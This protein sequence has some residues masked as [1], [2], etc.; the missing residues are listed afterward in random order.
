MILFII[1]KVIVIYR[2]IISFLFIFLSLS[3]YATE[4]LIS[5]C[6]DRTTNLKEAEVSL[7]FLLL[8]KEKVFQRP[9][10]NCLDITTS[11][12][13]ANLLEKFL[14]KRYSL[15]NPEGKSNFKNL[16]EQQCQIE[17]R[18]TKSLQENGKDFRLGHLNIAKQDS[19][20]RQ[21]VSTSQLLLGFGYP[22]T[23]EIGER[24]FYIECR[25]NEAGVYQL[26]FSYNESSR[27]RVNSTISIKRGE[28]V[29]LAQI[30]NDLDTKSKILGFPQSLYQSAQGQEDISYELKIN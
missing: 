15:V 22:G 3:I 26:I 27:A 14:S 5:Y 30:I 11:G 2:L 7:A 12:H 6:F 21:E 18:V 17:V 28:T 13:R 9:E 29:L 10:Q 24:S 23:L 1:K 16:L 4:G 8:A 20:T 19:H 25:K